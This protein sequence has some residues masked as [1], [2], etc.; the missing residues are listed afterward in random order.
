MQWILQTR[1]IQQIQWIQWI[2]LIWWIQQIAQVIRKRFLSFA[3]F[4]TK[5]FIPFT[6]LSSELHLTE[7]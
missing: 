4:A 1:R 2:R 6:K 7:G 5:G 3:Y